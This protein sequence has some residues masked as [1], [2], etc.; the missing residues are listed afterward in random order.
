MDTDF[1]G[2][3]GGCVETSVPI[4]ESLHIHFPK[5]CTN[6]SGSRAHSIRFNVIPRH[7]L[8]IRMEIKL[9]ISVFL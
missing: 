9:W 5:T 4:W 1:V 3:K 6:E 2:T 7:K 8:D